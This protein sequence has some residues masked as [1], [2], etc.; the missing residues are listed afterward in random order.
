MTLLFDIVAFIRDL[1][2]ESIPSLNT[3]T[4]SVF[5]FAGLSLSTWL[6]FFIGESTAG[7]VGL[8][9]YF[10]I[11]GGV[12]GYGLG[13]LTVTATPDIIK[14]TTSKYSLAS[15]RWGNH[16]E[17]RTEERKMIKAKETKRKKE[18]GGLS[19][20]N[21]FQDGQLSITKKKEEKQ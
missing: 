16:V 10:G 1:A 3:F 21:A 2:V 17:K 15:R 6:A 8:I 11:F 9:I 7:I 19:V 18:A 12:L 20:I 5:T 14:F 13:I 4:I